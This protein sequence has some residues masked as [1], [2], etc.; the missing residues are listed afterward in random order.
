M[1]KF[2]ER[3]GGEGRFTAPLIALFLGF[4]CLC[5]FWQV[6]AFDFVYHDDHVYVTD[7]PRVLSGLTFSGLAWAFTTFDAGFWHPLTWV[8]LMADAELYGLHAGGYHGTNVLLHLLNTLFLFWALTRMTGAPWRSCLAAALFAAHPFHVEPVAWVAARKDLLA[9]LFFMLGL[10]AYAWYAEGP[11][12]HRYGLVLLMFT[13]GL[14]SKTMVVTLPGVF[15]LLDFWPLGR[16]E[17]AGARPGRCEKRSLGSLVREK[18]PLFLLGLIF[19][20]LTYYAETKVG[21]LK[22][23][24][25][26]PPEVR[27]VNA[28]VSYGIYLIKTIV[29]FHLSVFYPHPGLL[30]L[31]KGAAAAVAL[32]VMTG[33]VLHQRMKRPYL[34]VGWFWFLGTLLPVIGLVQIGV[35]GAADRYTYIPLIGLFLMVAWFLGE[36]AGHGPAR[37]V[38]I[39]FLAVGALSVLTVLSI[40][41]LRVWRNAETLFRHATAVT[42]G[43]YLAHNNLGAALARK[44]RAAEAVV[45]YGRALEIRSDYVEATF[46]MGA[47]LV[48][49]GRFPEA[50]AYYERV[51]LMKPDFAEAHNNLGVALAN[52]G[53]ITEARRQFEAAVKIRPDY[54]EARANLDLTLGRQREKTAAP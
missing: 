24:E 28:V 11:R 33:F 35:H 37:R 26:F 50:A 36:Q 15:L 19:I 38:V 14:M 53:C 29:P 42:R 41:Q 22:S 43:N 12:W 6:P 27:I 18:V 31:G 21:A 4:L 39:P 2:L 40:Y 48:D 44:G 46:N 13:L 51:L 9:T 45:E 47:A 49:L 25:Q 7:N 23:W 10:L 1:R 16:M 30:P 32:A 3:I 20:G 52:R 54:R 34:T 8:S 5:I 17:T